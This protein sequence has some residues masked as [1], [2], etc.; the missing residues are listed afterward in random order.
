MTAWSSLNSLSSSLSCS[1]FLAMVNKIIDRA[2]AC[3]TSS[4]GNSQLFQRRTRKTGGRGTCSH[5]SS[6]RTVIIMCTHTCGPHV[7][8]HTCHM[9]NICILE[10]DHN[11]KQVAKVRSWYVKVAKERE[12]ERERESNFPTVFGSH[13][14]RD[15]SGPDSSHHSQLLLRMEGLTTTVTG[16]PTIQLASLMQNRAS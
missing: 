8:D 4:P 12:R 6:G 10:Q 3:L 16:L 15:H 13:D 2:R 7:T 1:Q 9:I 14:S 11:R 5:V